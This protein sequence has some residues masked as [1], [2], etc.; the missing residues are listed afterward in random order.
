MHATAPP[1]D[2]PFLPVPLTPLVGREREL[3]ALHALVTRPDVRLVTV[4]G[5]GG[6]GKTR[7]AIRAARDLADHF[8]SGVRFVSLSPVGMPDLV[9]PTIARHLGIGE[10]ACGEVLSVLAEH[11]AGKPLLLVLDNCEHLLD[12]APQLAALIAAC[13]DLKTLATSRAALR[14]SGEHEFGVAPLPLPAASGTATVAEIAG[15]AAIQLFVARAAAVHAD[16]RLG[17][18]NAAA[19][20]RICRQVDGLPLAIELAAARVKVFPPQALLARLERRLPLLTGGPR[21]APQ[22]LR[23]MRDAIAW[24][25]DLLDA[26][27]Q[28]LFRH[29]AVFVGG[30]SLDAAEAIVESGS[31]PLLDGISSLVDK[32]LVVAAPPGSEPPGGVH[33]SEPRF[34]MLETIREFALEELIRAGED[35]TARRAH[36][37]VFRALAERA[38][39]ELRGRNQTLWIARLETELPNLRA[40]LDWS[41]AGGDPETGLRLAGALYW[42]WFLRNHVT[43]G[44]DWFRRARAAAAAPAGAAGKAALGAALLAWRHRDYTASKGL[45]EGALRHFEAAGDR[46]GTA[47][48][49]HHLGHVADDLDHD[50]ER[51]RTLLAESEERFAALGD[52]WGV[53]LSQRCLGRSWAE[54]ARDYERA[55][56]LLR[57]ALAAFRELD[58][59]WNIAVT[60]HMLG[61]VAL[62]REHWPDAIASYRE[63]L[64]HHWSQR[65]D[66]GVADALLRLAQVLVGLGRMEDATRFFGAAEARHEEAGVVVYEPVRRGYDEA[67]STARAALGNERFA[68]RWNEGRGLALPAVAEMALAMQADFPAGGNRSPAPPTSHPH[69]SPRERDVLR[70]IVAGLSDREI[71]AALSIGRRTVNTHVT[72]ILN[73]LAVGSR[74][75]AAAYA[76]R[77]DLA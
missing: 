5:P 49:I 18:D 9:L 62:A 42:F 7:L 54:S 43:E 74:T 19:V 36:A 26:D 21:D 77:H 24:S 6:V 46:W 13:P 70:L 61:D 30:F 52:P 14:V 38:E 32:S 25:Y 35:E 3:A 50:A 11:L 76:L 29:L 72:S 15:S 67:V 63:S 2:T 8:A 20:A 48:A 23:T 34:T 40:V 60:L 58:D 10:A 47:M 28:R 71:A 16:F 55:T 69:L 53:A 45:A 56:A 64:A 57:V 1:S 73:K 44:R 51:S 33:V 22:R 59:G 41:L 65:D 17:L 75:A 39:P 68:A 4:T 31:L 27:E 12:A 66:L 37:N